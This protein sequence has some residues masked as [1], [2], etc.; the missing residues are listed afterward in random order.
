LIALLRSDA[1][2]R[3]RADVRR[4]PFLIFEPA[5]LALR[6]SN[7]L[8]GMLFGVGW[9][10]AGYTVARPWAAG[11]SLLVCGVLLVVLAIALGG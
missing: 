5:R 6:I 9:S 8:L 11:P 4:A 10:W 1:P 3:D 2:L 7:L